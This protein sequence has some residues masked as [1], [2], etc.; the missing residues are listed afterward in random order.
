MSPRFSAQMESARA[1]FPDRDAPTREACERAGPLWQRDGKHF[2]KARGIV[3]RK[4]G[5]RSENVMDWE[6][7]S[8]FRQDRPAWVEREGLVQ[9]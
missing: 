1:S 5:W 2:E 4:L 8:Y 7:R 6:V 9:P 3:A